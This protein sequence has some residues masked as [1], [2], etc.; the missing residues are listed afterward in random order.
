MK[1]TE[2]QKAIELRKQGKSM[3]YISTFLKVSKS[4]IS[5]WVR[6]VVLTDLQKSKISQNGRNVE[7][8]EKR[9][10]NRLFNEEQKRNRITNEAKEDF[11]SISLRE[12]KLIGIILYLGEGGK[13]RRNIVRISN[14][15]PDII[16]IMMRFFR[17]ICSVRESKFAGHIHTFLHNDLKN[18]EK[19]WSEITGIPVDQFYK[20]YTKTSSASLKKRNTLP[21]G[22]FDI[23]I[24]DTKL[25]LKIMGWIDKIKEITVYKSN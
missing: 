13:T 2:R 3:N 17:E 14:S 22:T 25:F 24:C 19:Y 9:R 6:D 11:K 21:F 16:K 8:I 7:S 10:K 5:L 20:T 15:D 18:T 12:L 1:N 4:S 23:Y